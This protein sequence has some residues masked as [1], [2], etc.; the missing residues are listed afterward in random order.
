MIRSG[1]L[2]FVEGVASDKLSMP[3]GVSK[4]RNP[5]IARVFRELKLIEQ[6]G[7]GIPRIFRETAAGGFPEPYF[8]ELGLRLRFVFPLTKAIENTP[9]DYLVSSE[10]RLA[11]LIWFSAELIEPV[12]P[13]LRTLIGGPLSAKEL[14]NLMN[15][16]HRPSFREQYLLP[17]LTTR[18]IEMTIPEKPNSQ[19]QK[20]RLTERGE[21]ALEEASK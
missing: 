8:V 21:K 4:I 5:V 17:A 7:S 2:R 18:F 9:K 12:A 16:K 3:A 20:Y 6:W 14:R 1:Q 11:P 19:L 10:E 15:Y 13:I